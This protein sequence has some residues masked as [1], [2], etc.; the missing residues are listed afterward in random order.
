MLPDLYVI[1]YY[2]K[3]LDNSTIDEDLTT[4]ESGNLHQLPLK[5]N[6]K[7]GQVLRYDNCLI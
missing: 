3:K 6:T 1:K 2:T 4:K 7:H 5:T